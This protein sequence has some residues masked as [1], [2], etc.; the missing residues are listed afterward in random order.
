[1]VM[2][3]CKKK[4]GKSLCPNECETTSTWCNKDA[5]GQVEYSVNEDG[6]TVFKG[7]PFV[8]RVPDKIAQRCSKGNVFVLRFI[9]H[10]GIGRSE[11]HQ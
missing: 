4:K 10:V 1:M 6:D 8:R 5:K 11:I 7:C 3:R 9:S 2:A